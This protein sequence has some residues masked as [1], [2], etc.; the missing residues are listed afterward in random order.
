M[1]P[2]G[3]P[4]HSLE[5]A[6]FGEFIIERRE[7]IARYW[8]AA[9]DRSA[10]I[11][12]SE[13]LT[14][15]QLLDHLPQICEELASV[16]QEPTPELPRTEANRPSRV[17]GRK[18]WEQGY[19]LD[20][21]LREICIIRRD[22]LG[23]W[24]TAFQEQRGPMESATQQKAKQIVDWF[25]DDVMID[26]AVQFVEEQHQQM[27]DVHSALQRQ[28][29]RAEAATKAKSEFLGLISHDLRTPLAPILLEATAWLADRRVPPALR[30]TL[31][32][33]R[34]N[35]EMEAALVDDL[36]DAARLIEGPLT[37][38]RRE[39]DVQEC[40]TAAAQF[41]AREF[42]GKNIE[43]SVELLATRSTIAGDATR[44]RRALRTL[45]RNA[46]NVSRPGGHV[47]VLSRNTHHGELQISVTDTGGGIEEQVAKGL[48]EPF[49]HGRLSPYG[50]HGV[51][52]SRFVCKGIIEAHGG[53]VTAASARTGSGATLTITLP[54]SEPTEAAPPR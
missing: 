28:T 36:L 29:T 23:R 44:L 42:A 3:Q 37:I 16:L 50:L 45:L 26:S 10:H 13:D 39:T 6:N 21:V 14:F 18:R 2:A 49:E 24:L 8:V 51:G 7:D 47:E 41:C 17:H 27:R 1:T 31:A 54:V 34:H 46:A 32:M 25:F 20:E 48:F 22:F 12:A 33:I 11:E 52:V 40:I 4:Q 15:R 9:V 53:T 5:L 30:E 35:A 38:S 43:L 19:R